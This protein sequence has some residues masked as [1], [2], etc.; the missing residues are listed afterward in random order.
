MEGTE[1]EGHR[2]HLFGRV[3]SGMKTDPQPFRPCI[4]EWT[5]GERDNGMVKDLLGGLQT[6]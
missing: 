5:G 2:S 6:A 3:L 4:S 1:R